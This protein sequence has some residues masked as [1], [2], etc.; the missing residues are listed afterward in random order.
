MEGFK[1]LTIFTEAD[2]FDRLAVD[3][4]ACGM[5]GFGVTDGRGEWKRA[6]ADR[7]EIF[8]GPVVRLET[9]VTPAVVDRAMR[10]LSEKY[11]PH[12]AV[13]AWVSDAQVLRP[14][15]YSE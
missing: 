4:R 13:F 14:E 8:D 15:R 11:F 9:V 12:Y 2:I 7:D 1:L 3:L 6:I 5:R 10:V